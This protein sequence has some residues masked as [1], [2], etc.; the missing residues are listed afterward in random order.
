MVKSWHLL[1]ME[2]PSPR[3][4]PTTLSMVV[5]GTPDS[6]ASTLTEQ[7]PLSWLMRLFTTS[8]MS[9]VP[10]DL[11][12]PPPWLLC[13]IATSLTAEFLHTV[14]CL[15]VIPKGVAVSF[16]WSPTSMDSMTLLLTSSIFALLCLFFCF[17]KKSV[18]SCKVK[19]KCYAMSTLHKKG[20]SRMQNLA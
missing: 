8:F 9:S 19:L 14:H 17:S 11:G 13:R 5:W 4:L 2:M 3:F 20:R 6:F 10:V 7:S 1:F 18:R 15:G 12:P 16:L